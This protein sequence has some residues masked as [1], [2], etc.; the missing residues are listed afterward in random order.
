MQNLF[1]S[2]V[3]LLTN[4]YALGVTSKYIATRRKLSHIDAGDVGANSSP[5]Y[6]P[7]DATGLILLPTPYLTP[8]DGDGCIIYQTPVTDR[9]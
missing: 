3:G 7:E 8:G 6:T 5:Q 1:K 9:A 2:C 4:L